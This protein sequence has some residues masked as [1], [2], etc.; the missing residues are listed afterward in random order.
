[1]PMLLRSMK[2]YFAVTN[3]G[4]TVAIFKKFDDVMIYASKLTAMTKPVVLNPE[5]SIMDAIEEN[6]WAYLD[7]DCETYTV[8]MCPML[9]CAATSLD[10]K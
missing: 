5:K 3:N 7:E 2:D 6:G 8:S 10:Q 9:R 1:M 4:V